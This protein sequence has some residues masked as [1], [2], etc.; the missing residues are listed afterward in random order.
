MSPLSIR[1]ASGSSPCAT[2]ASASTPSTQSESSS[3]SSA[4]TPGTNTPAPAW[5]SPSARRS[6]NGAADA[7]GSSPQR[8]KA[9]RSTSPCRRGGNHRVNGRVS[10]TP[11]EILLVEDNPGDARLMLEVL[12]DFK[13]TNNVSVAKDG[14]EALAF[15]SRQDRKSV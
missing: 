13:I 9:Q 2:T 15:M 4:S 11:V 1:R 6:W 12:K 5:A 8:E 7:S 10:G 14:V 3:S